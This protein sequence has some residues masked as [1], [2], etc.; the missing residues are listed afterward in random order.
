MA[1]RYLVQETFPQMTGGPRV[2]GLLQEGVIRGA[3]TLLLE[4]TGTPVRVLSFDLHVR[5]T[6]QGQL[7]GLLLHPEDAPLVTVGAT[8]VGRPAG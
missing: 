1:V 3:E 5:Q 7:V 8:L 4:D 6:A 2:V